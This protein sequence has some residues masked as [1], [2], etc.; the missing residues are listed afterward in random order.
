[1]FGFP[2]QIHGYFESHRN[3]NADSDRFSLEIRG[4]AGI[5][6]M[7][8][9]ADVILFEG[10]SFNPAKPHRWQPLQIPAW[11][12]LPDKYRWCHQQLIVDLLVAAE[13][14][15]EPITGIHHTR[16]A[17][18]MIQSVYV[19]HLAQSRVALPLP[20]DQRAHPLI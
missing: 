11:D 15:R 20:N 17:Q 6:A 13:E 12:A 4:S 2:D 18:E 16:W 1:M 19:S 14:N 8:S 9:L 7:R 3:E 10:S 5:I